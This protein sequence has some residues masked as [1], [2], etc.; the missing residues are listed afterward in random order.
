MSELITAK[1]LVDAMKKH[2]NNAISNDAITKIHQMGVVTEV[3]IDGTHIY[4][5]EIND[6]IF[7]IPCRSDLNLSIGNIVIIMCFNGNKSQRWIID[8]KDWTS[9]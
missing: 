7:K 9:W 5:I 6:E 8:K 3:P 4:T 2:A 1:R